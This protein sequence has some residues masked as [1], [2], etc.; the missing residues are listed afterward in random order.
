M[1]VDSGAPAHPALDAL[2]KRAAARSDKPAIAVIYPCEAQALSACSE[3]VNANI[4]QLTLV[5]PSAR[6]RALAES[7]KLDLNAVALEDTPDDPK[8][9]AQRAAEMVREG[10]AAVLMKGS[11]HT[12]ELMAVLVSRDAGLRT[13]RRISHAF[14]FSLPR[15]HKPLMLADCVVNIAPDLPTKRDIV[16]NAVDLAHALSID[17]PKVAILSATES[18]NPA[19]PGTLDAAALCKMADRGQL[20]GAIID[21]PLAFDN[22]IS[23]EAARIKGIASEVAGD[24]DILIAPNLE[25]GNTLYKSFVY[26]AGAECAG[27]VLGARVPV[28]LT[29]RAD[30]AYARLASAALGVLAAR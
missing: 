21:G 1:A 2:I 11:L 29:S 22:A 10:K 14:Y 6:I 26:L 16:Q 27:L 13:S 15:F 24:P 30:S 23:A 28:V 25:T 3:I 9:A 4:G 20:S 18:V 7:L 17:T 19:L 8:A 12:D 5:G